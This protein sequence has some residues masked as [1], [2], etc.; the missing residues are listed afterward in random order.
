MLPKHGVYVTVDPETERM[1]RRYVQVNP[2]IAN[3]ISLILHLDSS[4]I[5]A[6]PEQIKDKVLDWACALE[7]AGVTGEGL[8]FS[9]KEKQIADTVV[10]NISGSHI[11]QLNNSG[12]N[13][14][15]I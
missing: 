8:T 10:F 13:Q 6:I 11:E 12:T 14:K 5:K 4:Q 1:I 15:G 2:M 9:A 3:Q 7:S